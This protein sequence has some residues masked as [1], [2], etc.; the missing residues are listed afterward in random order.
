M[1]LGF[2]IR[3]YFGGR[4]CFRFR[5]RAADHIDTFYYHKNREG[6]D[7]KLDHGLDKGAVS[8]NG[9]RCLRCLQGG[10]GLAVQGDEKIGKVNL[11]GGD[12]DDR[13]KDIVYQGIDDVAEGSADNDTDSHIH[14]IA[15]HDEFFEFFCDL[16]HK[17]FLLIVVSSAHGLLRALHSRN[18]PRYSHI[19]KLTLHFYAHI[20]ACLKIISHP[21]CKHRCE[22][23]L[24]TL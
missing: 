12:A 3:T 22:N 6:N 4:C 7:Q 20:G 11:S 21:L 5:L 19:V 24:S 8:E 9:S 13:H 23:D 17:E 18:P 16:A 2:T 14:D 15:A 10:V 1:N